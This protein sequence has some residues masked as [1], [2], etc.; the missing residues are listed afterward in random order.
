[1]KR[2]TEQREFEAR[3]CAAVSET[4]ANWLREQREAVCVIRWRGEVGRIFR[5]VQPMEIAG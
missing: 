1:M 2:T 5:E 3:M 4:T